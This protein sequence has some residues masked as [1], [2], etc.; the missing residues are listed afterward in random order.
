R[1]RKLWKAMSLKCPPSWV[2]CLLMRWLLLLS[3]LNHF[4]RNKH[5]IDSLQ[6]SKAELRG[7]FVGFGIL[8]FNYLLMSFACLCLGRQLCPAVAMPILNAYYANPEK[9]RVGPASVG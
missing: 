3:T 1:V 6:W 9:S 7:R 2:F 4:R 8:Y 5:G